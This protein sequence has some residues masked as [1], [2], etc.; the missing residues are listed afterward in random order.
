MAGGIFILAPNPNWAFLDNLGA[1]AAGGTIQTFNSDNPTQ[2]QPVYMD[3]LGEN[4]WPETINLDA[5]GKQ[6]ALDGN[7]YPIY[8]STAALY[9]VIVKD[10]S[11][12]TIIQL[13][14]FPLSY[15]SAAGD[16]ST[17]NNFVLNP[18]FRLW[19]PQVL[20][21]PLPVS[22]EPLAPGEFGFVKSNTSANDTI[23][24][25]AFAVGQSVVPAN[26]RFYF[27]YDCPGAG[28][29]ETSKYLYW[30]SRDVTTFAGRTIAIQFWARSSLS[31]V[32]SLSFLQ[33]FGA[34]GSPDVLTSINTITLSTSWT[35]YQLTF[36]V[37]DLSGK[38]IG[39]NGDDFIEVQFN[40]PLNLASNFQLT[41]LDIRPGSTYADILE[42][43]L[44]E[45]ENNCMASLLQ[46]PDGNPPY[47]T[48]SANPSGYVMTVNENSTGLI[49][50]PNWVTGMSIPFMNT[51]DQIPT[52]FIAWATGT[53]GNASSNASLR[54][55]ADTVKL[56]TALWNGTSANPLNCQLYN[57]S[58]VATARGATAAGDYAQNYAIALPP[59][60]GRV[61][62]IT[63]TSTYI[64]P[65]TANFSANS[66]TVASISGG[67]NPFQNGTLVML[68]A[69]GGALPTGLTAGPYYTLP[70]S[71]TT[72]SLCTTQANV[73]TAT[74]QTFSD[75]GT[76]TLFLT[77]VGEP[78][79][80]FADAIGEGTD[81]LI[82]GTMPGHN[83]YE[84][85]NNNGGGS[86]SQVDVNTTGGGPPSQ[87]T[88]G[89][90]T[91]TT[92]GT[93]PHNNMQPTVFIPWIV[94]L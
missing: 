23:S 65:F 37:P 32:V 80:N 42:Q 4:P 15:P 79:R 14:Q 47:G 34:S 63:G 46:V 88:T 2:P 9:T 64:T 44:E 77:I 53:I 89:S 22:I 67:I 52:G 73:N 85:G 62:G 26:P 49:A 35:L 8:W 43:S 31:S 45:V 5:S 50:A 56:F 3:P 82:V 13:N 81:L 24:F 51:A 66:L 94:K 68:S 38:S 55:N 78:T 74:V 1:I 58:G 41:N 90:A 59:G 21:S 29:G 30:T 6:V 48:Q 57:S 10:A 84:T 75:N 76:G 69:V 11:G 87:F 16:D 18:Q 92:G 91:T 20:T 28:S 86:T 39:P 83:H 19:W 40:F 7:W 54:A 60:P 12:N 33:N 25:P 72:L 71:P 93:S 17:P 61:P 27:Q 36:D 70:L